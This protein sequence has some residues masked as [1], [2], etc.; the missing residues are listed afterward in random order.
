MQAGVPTTRIAKKL[1]LEKA[2]PRHE[3]AGEG[4]GVFPNKEKDSFERKNR[5]LNRAR[6]LS[7][8]LI[9]F[10]FILIPWSGKR[11]TLPPP[12]PLRTGRE[13]SLIRLKPSVR[14]SK[15]A[16]PHRKNCDGRVALFSPLPERFEDCMVL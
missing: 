7:N 4:G 16:A 5:P 2:L 13:S 11:A 14:S 1:S 8:A 9:L 3:D 12:S 6:L 15:N 10:F